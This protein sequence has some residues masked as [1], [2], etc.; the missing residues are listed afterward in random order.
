LRGRKILAVTPQYELKE[1]EILVISIRILC[2]WWDFLFRSCCSF[3]HID[4]GCLNHIAT[5]DTQDC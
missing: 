1:L 2:S 3:E 4:I 5:S